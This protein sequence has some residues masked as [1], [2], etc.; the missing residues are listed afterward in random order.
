MRA[1]KVY[2]PEWPFSFGLQQSRGLVQCFP[3]IDSA[4]LATYHEPCVILCDHPSLRFGESVSLL[5]AWRTS[6]LNTVVLTDPDYDA[7]EVR[8]KTMVPFEWKYSPIFH[9]HR[10]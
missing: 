7:A 3:A 2:I 4:F 6:S 5:S 9:I 1:E 8:A 10:S